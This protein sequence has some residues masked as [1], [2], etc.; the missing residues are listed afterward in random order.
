MGKF[1]NMSRP[2]KEGCVTQVDLICSTMLT[3]SS[4]AAFYNQRTQF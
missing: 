4:I 2:Y 1:S 3:F